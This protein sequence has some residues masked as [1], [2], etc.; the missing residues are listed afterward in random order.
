MSTENS[1]TAKTSKS[2][3]IVSVEFNFGKNLGESVEMF[4]E[5][6]VHSRYLSAAVIDLQALIRRGINA[7][8]TDEEIAGLAA[9]W[10]PGVKTVVRKSAQEKI[11]DA[12]SA[13]SEEDR[14]EMLRQ[15]KEQMQA[16]A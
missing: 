14:L 3:R 11:K 1:V 16:E 6:V 7:D 10:K 5:D 9:A 12:F 13:M 4:G 8:K 15:L 2:D